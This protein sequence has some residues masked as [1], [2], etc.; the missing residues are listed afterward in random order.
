MTTCT[1]RP[2]RIVLLALTLGMIFAGLALADGAPNGAG[3]SYAPNMSVATPQ[4]DLSSLGLTPPE[5]TPNSC[6][7][8]GT[9]T[10]WWKDSEICRTRNTCL[11]PGQQI[12]GSCP[13]GYDY[14]VNETII[15]WCPYFCPC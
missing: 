5:P 3:K 7:Y 15:C 1:L 14:F 11:P 9:Y 4:N 12:S 2:T 10:E 6:T 8:F 13:N